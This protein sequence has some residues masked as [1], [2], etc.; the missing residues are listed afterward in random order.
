MQGDGNLVI[1]DTSNKPLWSSGTAGRGVSKFIM[2]ED[3]N[4]VIYDRNGAPSWSSG[5]AGLQ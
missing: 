1:Y 2:Q 3:G 5:T 4:L